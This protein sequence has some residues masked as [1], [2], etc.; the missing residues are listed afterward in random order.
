LQRGREQR[1]QLEKALQALV[2]ASIGAV[3]GLVPLAGEAQ[4]RHRQVELGARRLAPGQIELELPLGERCVGGVRCVE[5]GSMVGG[6][7]GRAHGSP[8]GV[9]G[10]W[11][12]GSLR[13]GRDVLPRRG[14][15]G[16]AWMERDTSVLGSGVAT[17]SGLGGGVS[18]T[19]GQE[20]FVLTSRQRGGKL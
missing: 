14:T 9:G 5:V 17:L 6:D 19:R 8:R 4:K 12:R 1:A 15:D 7:I 10:L 3:G 18:K 16:A 13:R 2:V 20:S 11:N